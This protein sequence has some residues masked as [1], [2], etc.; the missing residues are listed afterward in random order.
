MKTNFCNVKQKS[1]NVYASTLCTRR[2]KEKHSFI[3]TIFVF[4]PNNNNNAQIRRPSKQTDGVHTN[5]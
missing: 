4:L 5:K 2:K 3:N 1:D